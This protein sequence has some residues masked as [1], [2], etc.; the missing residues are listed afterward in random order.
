MTLQERADGRGDRRLL[1]GCRWR[2]LFYYRQN[3]DLPC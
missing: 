3:H 1:F 2:T